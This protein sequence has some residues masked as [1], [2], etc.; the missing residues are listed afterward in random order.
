MDMPKPT[1]HHRN[2]TAFIGSWQGEEK[3]HP[4]AFDPQG[5]PAIGRLTARLELE[6]FFVVADYAQERAGKT[7]YRGHAVFGYDAMRERYTMYWFD[8]I[9][10]DP[11]GP[12]LARPESDNVFVFDMT[13]PMG[14]HRY[15]YRFEGDVYEMHIENSPDG[16]EWTTFLEGTYRRT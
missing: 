11:G 3:I 10:T 4:S 12:A 5:G 2:L 8:T 15:T 6:G 14:H 7:N 13:S 16:K 1:V 9:G